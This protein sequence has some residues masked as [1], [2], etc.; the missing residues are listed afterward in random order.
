MIQST[1]RHQATS[2][3]NLKLLFKNMIE[4]EVICAKSN[5][6]SHKTRMQPRKFSMLCTSSRRVSD[7]SM[8]RL[9]SNLVR[10]FSLNL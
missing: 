1:L 3:Q 8:Y 9:S 2:L 5:F 7:G 4:E 6:N 10:E